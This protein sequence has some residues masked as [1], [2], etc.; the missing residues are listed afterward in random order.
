[1]HINIKKQDK[2]GKKK[3]KSKI[4]LFLLQNDCWFVSCVLHYS[5]MAARMWHSPK[6]TGGTGKLFAFWC[7][8]PI[9]LTTGRDLH[10]S[11]SLAV[12][13]RAADNLKC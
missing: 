10:V 13:H 11:H 5:A 4:R 7:K 12:Y 1:M 3:G 2:E 9:L 8:G 6:V